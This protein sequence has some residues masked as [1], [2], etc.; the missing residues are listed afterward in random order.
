M[1]PP[2]HL[3][4]SKE[5]KQKVGKGFKDWRVVVRLGWWDCYKHNTQFCFFSAPSNR[6]CSLIQFSGSSKSLASEEPLLNVYA[7]FQKHCWHQHPFVPVFKRLFFMT[8]QALWTKSGDAVVYP[9]HAIVVSLKVSSNQQRFFTGHTDKVKKL[10]L[11]RMSDGKRESK[12][13][14]EMIQCSPRVKDEHICSSST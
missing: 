12:Y 5:D 10:W 14:T 2:V 6:S 3:P 1:P 11:C 8:S 9:C 13:G 7:T 4:L